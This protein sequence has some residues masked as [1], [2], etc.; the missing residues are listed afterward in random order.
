[1]SCLYLYF[2]CLSFTHVSMSSKDDCFEKVLKLQYYLLFG[3]KWFATTFAMP[4]M[5]SNEDHVFSPNSYS[6]DFK[7][8]ALQQRT[9]FL[10]NIFL[11]ILVHDKK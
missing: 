9:R 5:T 4:V 2:L 8:L 1:M 3:S 10:L 7:N 6:V 11:C